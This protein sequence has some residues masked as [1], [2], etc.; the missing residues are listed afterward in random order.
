MLYRHDWNFKVHDP[1]ASDEMEPSE[2]LPSERIHP[3]GAG[4]V[5]YSATMQQSVDK[6]ARKQ[7]LPPSL[8]VAQGQQPLAVG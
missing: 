3:H 7:L 6:T 4:D 8:P 2:A 5:H 1:A